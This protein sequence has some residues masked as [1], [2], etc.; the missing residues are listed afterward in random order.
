VARKSI[1]PKLFEVRGSGIH[2]RGVFAVAAIPKG[3]RLI[4]YLGEKITGAQM[5]ARYATDASPHTFVFSLSN[6]GYLDATNG[7]N[8]ARFIN[9]SCKPNCESIEA[10]G[11]IFIEATR[12]IREGEE[13]SYDYGI[14]LVERHTKK[15]KALYAC[16]CGKR[17]CKGTMLAEK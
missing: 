11:R 13:L 5:D 12:A 7:G 9:H 17:G 6:G 16:R 14:V 1:T 10:G 3:T 15:R 4:E 8:D 2:G